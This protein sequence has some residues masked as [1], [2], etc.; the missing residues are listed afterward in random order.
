MSALS[1]YLACEYN[2]HVP[3]K[4]T[5]QLFDSISWLVSVAYLLLGLL[6][7]LNLLFVVNFGTV[8]SKMKSIVRRSFKLDR[9]NDGP[10]QQSTTNLILEVKPQTNNEA[11]VNLS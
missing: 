9:S 6:P 7:S 11:E 2:G 10:K 3:G 4:C 8:E 5:K 1:N